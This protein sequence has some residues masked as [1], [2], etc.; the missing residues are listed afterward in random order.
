MFQF[1]NGIFY[2]YFQEYIYLPNFAT[3]VG[4]QGDLIARI[5]VPALPP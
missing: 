4:D 3:V 2:K 1:C 5:T